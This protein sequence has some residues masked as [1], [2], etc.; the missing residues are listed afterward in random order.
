[1]Q[2]A[3]CYVKIGKL[4]N[5]FQTYKKAADANDTKAQLIVAQM[6]QDGKGVDVDEDQSIKYLEKA[7]SLGSEEAVEQLKRIRENQKFRWN[8]P[9]Y[10]RYT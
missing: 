1:M 4:D 7:A 5:A 10:K 3:D 8:S 2:L 6:Y 9:F